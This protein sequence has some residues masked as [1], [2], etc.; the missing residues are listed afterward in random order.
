MH[1][2]FVVA[3]VSIVFIF[4]VAASAAVGSGPGAV[5]VGEISSDLYC[6][7]KT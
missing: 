6:T 1:V 4:D 5:V 2:S 3:F 7:K